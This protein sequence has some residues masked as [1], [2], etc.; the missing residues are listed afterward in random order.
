VEGHRQE[1]RH[2]AGGAD[3]GKDADQVAEEA[4]ERRIEQVRGRQGRHEAARELL[5]R[6]HAPM[7]FS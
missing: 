4:A 7:L 2:A 1:H 3:A 5:Q 6:I